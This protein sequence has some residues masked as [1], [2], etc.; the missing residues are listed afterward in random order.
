[1]VRQSILQGYRTADPIK[2]AKRNAEWLSRHLS[3][4]VG[5]NIAVR[6]VV[7]LPGWYV[8]REGK[9]DIRVVNSSEF[10]TMVRGTRSVSLEMSMIRRLVHQLDALCRDV[11]KDKKV[12]R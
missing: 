3:S 12:V 2:Q 10:G 9:S 4:A 11:A 5:E 7:A 1:M 6:S 8:K